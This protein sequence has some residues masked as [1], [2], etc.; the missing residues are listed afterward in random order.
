M[1]RR[2]NRHARPGGRHKL[3]VAQLPDDCE[4]IINDNIALAV[5]HIGSCVVRRTDTELHLGVTLLRWGIFTI[6]GMAKDQQHAAFDTKEAEAAAAHARMEKAAAIAPALVLEVTDR[7]NG[8]AEISPDQARW[9]R[10]A[11]SDITKLH[12]AHAH[13]ECKVCA[14]IAD[15][16]DKVNRLT[17]APTYPGQAVVTI[18]GG[19]PLGEETPTERAVRA[20]RSCGDSADGPGDTFINGRDGLCGRCAAGQIATSLMP[21]PERPERCEHG[22]AFPCASCNEAIASSEAPS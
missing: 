11:V 8:K 6:L 13:D 22:L 2:R 15:I 12:G 18:G 4:R 5:R 21:P 20:C 16:L 1:K 10:L 14:E 17:A 3:P 9:L 19:E 7:H